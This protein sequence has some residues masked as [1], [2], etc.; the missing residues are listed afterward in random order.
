MNMLPDAITSI[1]VPIKYGVVNTQ[2]GP[3][4]YCATQI[5]NT[6]K[7]GE[8]RGFLIVLKLINN[9]IINQLSR[10]TMT[11]ITLVDM[12]P[13]LSTLA[14]SAWT[15]FIVPEKLTATSQLFINDFNFQIF[16]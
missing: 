10:H 2:H 16:K 11:E 1:G 6:D 9:S 4:L 15:D 13:A 7:S 5:R 8:N 3:A 14:L 12:T